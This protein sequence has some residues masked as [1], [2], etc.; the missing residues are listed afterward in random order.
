MPRRQRVDSIKAQ[1]VIV[2]KVSRIIDPPAHLPLQ[3]GDVPFWE[4][5]L[6]EFARTEWTAHQLELAAMLA[7]TMADVERNQMLIRSEG[8]VVMTERGQPVPNPR[9]AA[10]RMQMTNVLAYRRSLGVHARGKDGEARDVAK[11]RAQTKAIE[12][13]VTAAVDDFIARPTVN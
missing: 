3:A 9:L 7:R 2:A 8:E 11:R 13:E 12:A 6:G 5:V 10:L 1:Q 4:S